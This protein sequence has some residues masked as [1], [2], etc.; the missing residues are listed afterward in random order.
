MIPVPPV[1]YAIVLFQG[2]QAL[3]AFGP[4]DALNLIAR[5]RKIE[6]SIIGP[7][8][9][10]VS[11]L[12][13]GGNA[14]GA[15]FSQTVVPTHTYADPPSEIDVLIIPGGVGTRDD[16]TIG[17]VIELSRQLYPRVQYV[18]TVCTGS[19]VIARAGILDG[20]RATTNKVRFRSIAQDNPQVNWIKKARWVVDGNIWTSSGVT[21]GIDAMFAFL[22]SIY[23]EELAT[24]TAEM[25]EHIRHEDPDDD[26]FT[27]IVD[28]EN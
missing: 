1:H 7:S 25:M 13:P 4:L 15:G 5:E 9:D 18:F 17:P 24:R 14:S 10:P 28:R 12:P 8:L 6:L 11:T 16:T 19:S 23:G 22:K 20:K 26:P 3:D 21:A 27:Y 2:F